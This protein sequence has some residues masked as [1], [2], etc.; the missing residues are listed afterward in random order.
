M[1]DQET[2]LRY[3]PNSMATANEVFNGGAYDNNSI[4]LT[5]A[6]D[7]KVRLGIKKTTN[8]EGNWTIWDNWRLYYLGT[9][10]SQTPNGDPSGIEAVA[11]GNSLTV[12]YFTL[13]GRKATAAQQGIM[14]QKVTFAN[15]AV[16]VKKIRK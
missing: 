8:L 16:I 10:S 9:N 12:E 5:V 4:I 15:G 11:A 14:I 7:G 13:D 6:A 3:V 1:S 2:E